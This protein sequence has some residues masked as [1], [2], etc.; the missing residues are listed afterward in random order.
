[1]TAILG[2]LAVFAVLLA[3]HAIGILLTRAVN[4]KEILDWWD[5]G[6]GR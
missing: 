3:I 6:Q 4:A 1:M 2:T 5:E